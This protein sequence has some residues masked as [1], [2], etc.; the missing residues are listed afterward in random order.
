MTDTGAG[1]EPPAAPGGGV[2]LTNIRERLKALY[3]ERGDASLEENAP[4][5]VR[6]VHRDSGRP[7]RPCSAPGAAHEPRYRPSIADDE[8]LLR[9]QLRARLA[10]AWPELEVVHEMENGGE[11]VHVARRTSRAVVFLD[12]HMPA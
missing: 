5:G 2:G 4:R 12:I 3:G 11:A 8:P 10:E 6:G 1:F 9:A 7:P